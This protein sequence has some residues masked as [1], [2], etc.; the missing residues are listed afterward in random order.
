VSEPPQDTPAV[1]MVP[2]LLTVATVAR[3]LDCSPQTVRRRIADGS[4]AAVIEHGRLMVRADDLRAYVD[5]LQRV[6]NGA[7]RRRR[8]RPPADEFDFLRANAD[9]V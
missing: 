9:T 8:H 4:L 2:A 1:L 6:G 5:A 3:I 7:P